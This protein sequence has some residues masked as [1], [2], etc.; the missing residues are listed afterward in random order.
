MEKDIHPKMYL[1]RRVVAAK[2][3]IDAHYREKIDLPKMAEEAC[4]SKYHFLRLFKQAYGKSPH[5]YLTEVR[6]QAAKKLFQQRQTIAEV[7]YRVGF[8]SIP[9][10][11]HLF[12]KTIGVSPKVYLEQQKQL[13][14]EQ[15]NK[16]LH[17]IPNCFAENFGW[18]K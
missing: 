10:F 4:Y 6:I 16:P 11:T 9:S 1:Y 17:F 7:C 15:S 2:L 5:Q 14:I 12:K 18:R 3:Y 8:E 13:Q